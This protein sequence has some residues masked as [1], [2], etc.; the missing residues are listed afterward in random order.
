MQEDQGT[1]PSS[2]AGNIRLRG[3]FLTALGHRQD[4]PAPSGIAST[5]RQATHTRKKPPQVTTRKDH[6]WTAAMLGFGRSADG[7]PR[8]MSRAADCGFIYRITRKSVI[9][10]YV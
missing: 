4:G 5:S 9:L 2:L 7:V 8:V 3:A 1:L 6:H 10:S